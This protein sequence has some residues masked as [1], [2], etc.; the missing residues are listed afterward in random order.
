[1][2]GGKRASMREGPL[3][4]LFRGTADLEADDRAEKERREKEA[5]ETEAR[6]S[7]AWR[8]PREGAPDP[9]PRREAP[10]A[11]VAHEEEPEAPKVPSPQARLRAAFSAD[12]PENVMAPP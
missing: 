2:A 8:G 10:R 12:L 4:A 9:E 1:M 3:A 5:Q 11:A 6:A 7:E